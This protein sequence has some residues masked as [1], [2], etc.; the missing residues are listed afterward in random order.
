MPIEIKELVIRANMS[1]Q[2]DEEGANAVLL[3]KDID[4]ILELVKS[5]PALI[6]QDMKK[7]IVRECI[8][9]VKELLADEKFR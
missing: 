2:K 6:S 3:E 8:E 5:D 4:M 9:K 7:E 1:E